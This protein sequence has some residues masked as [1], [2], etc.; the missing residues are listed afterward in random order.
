M[1]IIQAYIFSYWYVVVLLTAFLVTI[2]RVG[3]KQAKI[4]I[5]SLMIMNR[6]ISSSK[7][8]DKVAG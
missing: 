1:S 7:T 4:Y 2:L 5:L 6:L 3:S 8:I